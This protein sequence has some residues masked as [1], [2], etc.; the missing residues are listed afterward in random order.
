MPTYMRLT[1]SRTSTT[2]FSV[3]LPHHTAADRVHE[4]DPRCRV[5]MDTQL[6][7]LGGDVLGGRHLDRVLGLDD[8]VVVDHGGDLGGIETRGVGID[9]IPGTSIGE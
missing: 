6:V 2:E 3:A 8:C 5:P 7:G 4:S 1:T 9:K